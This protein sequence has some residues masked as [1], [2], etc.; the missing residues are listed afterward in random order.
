V[1]G[2]GTSGWN[3]VA[4]CCRARCFRERRQSIVLVG[5]WR[6]ELA[7]MP[8]LGTV[9][10]FVAPG[11]GRNTYYPQMRIVG[12]VVGMVVALVGAVWTLQG[13]NSQLAPQS[14]MTGSRIWLIIGLATFVGGSAV[15]M[16]SWQR[17]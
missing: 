2:R 10:A 15:A 11:A 5:R 6:I 9:V 1:P 14:F 17:R 13:L 7:R 3:G 12:V 16:W 4:G 8:V